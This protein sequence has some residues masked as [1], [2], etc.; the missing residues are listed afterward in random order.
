M[1]P[2]ESQAQLATDQYTACFCQASAVNSTEQP[3]EHCGTFCHVTVCW[4]VRCMYL[5]GSLRP[6][7]MKWVM[8]K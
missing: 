8:S 5:W 4:L 7:I 2:G 6:V 3:A 1:S